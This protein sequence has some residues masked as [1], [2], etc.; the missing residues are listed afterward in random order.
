MENPGEMALEKESRMK[1][2]PKCYCCDQPVKES[3]LI[4]LNKDTQ[5]VEIAFHR[6]CIIPFQLGLDTSADHTVN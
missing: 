2:Q 3:D 4:V 6:D 5:E 1:E